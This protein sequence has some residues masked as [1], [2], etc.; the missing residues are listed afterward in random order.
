[1][2]TGRSF[3]DFD[4]RMSRI[5]MSVTQRVAAIGGR[6]DAPS[7]FC[8]PAARKPIE[9]WMMRTEMVTAAGAAERADLWLPRRTR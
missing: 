9:L 5:G 2:T 1:M 6:Y 7:R 4:E 3:V 8:S